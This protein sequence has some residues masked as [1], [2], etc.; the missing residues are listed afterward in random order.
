MVD[1]GRLAAGLRWAVGGRWYMAE[2]EEVRWA[3]DVGWREAREVRQRW[4]ADGRRRGM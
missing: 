2:P 1:G 4:V 3:V